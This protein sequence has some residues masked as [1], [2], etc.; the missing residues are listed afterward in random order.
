[1]TSQEIRDRYAEQ[2]RDCVDDEIIDAA[3]GWRPLI[4]RALADIELDLAGKPWRVLQIKEKLGELRIYT[5][6][7][8]AAAR[9]VREA[10]EETCMKCGAAGGYVKLGGWI[11]TLCDTCAQ[12]LRDAP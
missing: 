10:S 9:G 2:L 8:S 5:S 3:P 7:P 11:A 6:P 4:E 12:R 1:M